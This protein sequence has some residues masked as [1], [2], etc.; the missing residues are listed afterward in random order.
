MNTID[1]FRKSYSFY[2]ECYEELPSKYHWAALEI[3][4]LTTYDSS[5]DEFFV[6][7]IIE[8]S[9]AI[10][11]RET[12]EYIEDKQNYIIYVLVCQMFN[13]FDWIEWGTSIRGAWFEKGCD[14]YWL[15]DDYN[16]QEQVPFSEENIKAL[17]EFLEEDS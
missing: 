9:K 13:R 10:L 14:A 16:L 8:V 17:I 1:I 3:F 7:K 15:L 5:L 4:H 11:N 6:K 2:R 12:F